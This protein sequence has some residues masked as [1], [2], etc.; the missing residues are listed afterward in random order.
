MANKIYQKLNYVK[1]SVIHRLHFWALL[2]ALYKFVL[3]P[4]V[5]MLEL[6]FR[7]N[8]KPNMHVSNAF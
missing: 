1:I 8:L 4:M 7:Q 3:G 5:K 6:V 2:N